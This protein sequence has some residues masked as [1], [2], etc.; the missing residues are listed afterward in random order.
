MTLVDRVRTAFQAEYI[1]KDL[2]YLLSAMSAMSRVGMD[3]TDMLQALQGEETLSRP[4]RR[5]LSSIVFESESEPLS[6]VLNEKSRGYSKEIRSFLSGLA[7]ET[8]KGNVTPF[9]ESFTSK[10][11]AERFSKEK[12]TTTTEE[13]LAMTHS[14]V[15]VLGPMVLIVI[16]SALSSLS[17]P[18]LPLTGWFRLLF[19]MYVPTGTFFFTALGWKKE[20]L[21]HAAP[22]LLACVV[23]IYVGLS[24]YGFLS[25]VLVS[26]AGLIFLPLGLYELWIW[27]RERSIDRNLPTFLKD[28]AFQLLSGR[29]FLQ[30]L[31]TLAKKRYGELTQVLRKIVNG[32]ELGEPFTESIQLLS[33]E[34]ALSRR[35]VSLLTLL[36]RKGGDVSRVM[37]SVSDFSWGLYQIEAEKGRKQYLTVA[38]FYIFMV[39][40]LFLATSTL[41]ILS[42]LGTATTPVM[43][44]MLFHGSVISAVCTG[45]VAGVLSTRKI[46]VGGTHVFM[47]TLMSMFF[48]FY[49]W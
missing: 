40:F 43:A 4:T 9:L 10:L 41:W 33:H 15:F 32:I 44:K 38:F 36:M 46:G 3:L 27:F 13:I 29:D 1:E 14:T 12:E 25:D 34:T 35:V 21:K 6:V 26:S 30:T 5:L 42:T 7:V 45:L 31:K 19:L 47:F 48:Y 28:F 24:G 23:L 2:P 49:V 8:V 17:P 22:F 37:E 16:V 20:P 18:V 11:M 39:A